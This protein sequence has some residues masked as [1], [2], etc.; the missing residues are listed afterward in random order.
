MLAVVLVFVIC[1][2]AV[3][4]YAEPTDIQ[5]HWAR[6][7]INR[8]I[9]RGILFGG[10]G[11]TFKPDDPISRAEFVAIINRTFKYQDRPGTAFSDLKG[12]E[13]YA[14]DIDRAV[15]AGILQGN[16]GK[17][18]PNDPV[19]RQEAALILTRAFALETENKN[20]VNGFND[21]AAIPVWSRDAMNAMYGKGYLSGQPG[22][23]IA[24]AGK[25]SRAEA[26]KMLDNIVEDLK[27][28]PGEYT[29]VI[30]GNLVV[31]SAD[32]VLKSM[33][34]NGDLYLTQG[35]GD[36]NITLDGVTV[37]GRT[38]VAG[39]GDHS[40]VVKNSALNGKLVVL[41]KDGKI[42]IVAQGSTDIQAVVMQSG[43]TL[44]ESGA[45]GNG[46][47]DV[48]VVMAVAQ[49]Q[50]LVLDGSF[51]EVSVEAPGVEIQVAGGSV[52]SLLVKGG[53]AGSNIRID[54]GAAVDVLTFDAAAAITGK[55][56]VN[57]ANIN[58]DG[59]TMEQAPAAINKK[60]G[61][62]LSSNLEE[63]L[64]GSAGDEVLSGGGG[65]GGAPGDAETLQVISAA[66]RIG[67][68]WVDAE[69]KR[70]GVWE[71][72]LTGEDPESMFTRLTVSASADVTRA[73]VSYMDF[74]RKIN[75]SDGS[76]A[77]DVKSILGVFDTGEPGVSIQS[78]KDFGETEFTVTIKNSSG[79]S[80]SV[81]IKLV[82]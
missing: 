26:V 7:E 33:T 3:S 45:T 2:F 59:V 53:G 76:A 56:A 25:T 57:T 60:D 43:G 36:G 24:P 66:A 77:I 73:E 74:T 31:N 22:N 69:E 55:G 18:R 21:A 51:D 80:A 79:R 46:F 71:V 5:G 44:E 35:I 29:G 39:G 41:K 10:T 12:S 14:A 52:G 61:V 64:N 11:G 67:G 47:G 48:Q 23:V 34:V 6:N 16:G 37:K 8:W 72:D 28:K 13:W 32:V 62:T 75:F 58:V 81:T 27:D 78:I 19:S 54:E 9:D 15:A 17:V 38:I 63:A 4:A 70:S 82:V 20:A 30:D 50:D 1:S 68:T 49:G 42:R 40:I 65:G